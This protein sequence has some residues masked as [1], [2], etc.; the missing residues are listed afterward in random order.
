[1]VAMIKIIG[2]L[3]AGKFLVQEAG[4]KLSRYFLY[5]MAIIAMFHFGSILIPSIV[6]Y[7]FIVIL[8][9]PWF[10]YFDSATFMKV[11]P[12]K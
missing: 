3:I 1:M 12:I 10:F 9:V 8:S 6:D 4:E 5:F 11:P 7:N 2:F